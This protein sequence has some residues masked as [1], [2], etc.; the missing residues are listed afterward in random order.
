M[1]PWIYILVAIFAAFIIVAISL[2]VRII[3]SYENGKL[4]YYAKILKIKSKINLTKRKKSKNDGDKSE[5]SL[6]EKLYRVRY[7]LIKYLGKFLKKVHF[8]LVKLRITIAGENATEAA[9]LYGAITPIISSTLEF[10]DS[11]S[12]VDIN[13]K[14]DI[15]ISTD[16]LSQKSSFEG[17]IVIRLNILRYIRWKSLLF[18]EKET[19]S[20]S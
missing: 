4:E 2:N 12:T 18:N 3:I 20:N 6:I 11:I 8:K 1:E 16:Y 10:L 13:N 15:S 5:E 7:S 17:K 9:L 19:N 14:S